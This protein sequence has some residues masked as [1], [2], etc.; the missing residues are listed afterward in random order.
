MGRQTKDRGYL[1]GQMLLAMP[2]MPDERFQRTLI[3]LCAHSA[4]G[5]MGIVVN[6]AAPGVSLP[7]L[8]VKLDVV[9]D[10]ADVARSVSLDE[11]R[12]PMPAS[13]IVV[14]RGGPVEQGRGF[15]LH[16][17]EFSIESSTLKI[18]DGIALTATLDILRAI[19]EGTGPATAVLALG[20]AVWSAG[21][22]E[23]EMQGNGWLHCAPDAALIFD[24]DLDSKYDRAL[25]TLGID[26]AMLSSDAGRA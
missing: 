16:S 19:A 25:R 14:L 17:D 8:L 4:E 1:D 13:D 10:E 7:E 9:K 5:A 3:Y 2:G 24:P 15:V 6:Q 22:L 12:R 26:L 18:D 20:Y 11:G 23:T 21:Q